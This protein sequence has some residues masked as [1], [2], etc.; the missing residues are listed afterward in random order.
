MEGPIRSAIMRSSS[1]VAG[2][3]F[4]PVF[5]HAGHGGLHN[6]VEAQVRAANAA[7][8]DVTLM[9]KAGPW[10]DRMS[11]LCRVLTTG[12]DDLDASTEA[13]LSAGPY[14]LVH[15]HPFASRKVGVQV[16]E[17]LG[18]PIVVTHHGP[19]TD[20]L[21][22]HPERIDMLVCVSEAARQKIVWKSKIDRARTVIHP[23]RGRP[24]HLRAVREATDAPAGHR[25]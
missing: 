8:Y 15:A 1:H 17:K 20:G 2:R 25:A 5:F 3:M 18:I 22:E 13:A 16:A 21:E 9:C 23:E 10:A 12:Y 11:P 19:Y 7:G 14:D 6:H 4:V 24:R